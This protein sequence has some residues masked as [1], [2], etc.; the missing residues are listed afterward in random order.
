MNI[1]VKPGQIWEY[2]RLG[3]KYMVNDVK[4]GCVSYTDLRNGQLRHETINYFKIDTHMIWPGDSTGKESSFKPTTI[5]I[6][7]TVTDATNA[8]LRQYNLPENYRLEYDSSRKGWL[9]IWH[10]DNCDMDGFL[11]EESFSFMSYVMIYQTRQYGEAFRSPKAA[12]RVIKKHWASILADRAAHQ[13]K[14]S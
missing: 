11:C 7:D 13:N 4:D 6:Y 2:R 5:V 12:I 10:W 8:L 14:K 1:D 3:V 9:A